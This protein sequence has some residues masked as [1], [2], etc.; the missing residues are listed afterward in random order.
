MN[1]DSFTRGRSGR[2]V[3]TLLALATAALLAAAFAGT[4]SADTVTCGETITSDTT[5]SNDV[6]PCGDTDGII[7]GADH[8]RL[9]LNGH[10]VTGTPGSRTQDRAAVVFRGVRDSRVI[11]GTVQ[12]FD[13]GVAING[14][15]HN[16]VRG[17]TARDNINYR[18]VTGR[19]T[20]SG[21]CDY[22]DGVVADSSNRNRIVD[23]QLV[24]NGPYSGAA[25]VG[26]SDRNRVAHNAVL[27]N[28]VPNFPPGSTSPTVCG[29]GVGPMQL[30]RSIQDIGVRVEG[31]GAN[32]NRV[33]HNTV[34]FSALMGIAIHPSVC[35]PPNG[36]PP[37]PND[38]NTVAGNDVSN[39]GSGG[40]DPVAD[41]IAVLENGPPGVVCPASG[42]TIRNNRS[43]DNDRDG[44]AIGGRGSG[45]NRVTHNAVNDNGQ[46]GLH[47]YGPERSLPG[48]I[49]NL[50]FN[51]QG[52][53]NAQWDGAD[54]NPGCDSNKWRASK[55]DK[56][57]QPCVNGP[58]Q[59][60]AKAHGH[61]HH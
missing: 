54:D 56:V 16:T 33:D 26:P 24:H 4:A 23:N 39:T 49:G 53:G 57:N 60:H 12:S 36:M 32:R 51:N 61:G 55:F 59:G 47:V 30:G 27:H 52:S 58:G 43:H 18:V 3:A 10:S 11:D 21:D 48:S 15:G 13:A 42:N 22:G 25:L 46:D 9:D 8:V 35:Q 17:V 14:G 29:T 6:G 38:D 37:M 7:I 41:G 5:L 44:I 50:L 34:A 2:R 19:D 45:H 28:D 1:V 20:D 31:P 40:Q